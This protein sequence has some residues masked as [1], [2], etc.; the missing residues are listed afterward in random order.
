M[1]FPSQI[2]S[3]T[4][5]IL[6]S[7]KFGPFSKSYKRNYYIIISSPRVITKAIIIK[8]HNQQEC[9][10]KWQE[11]Q[12]WTDDKLATNLTKD[13]QQPLLLLPAKRWLTRCQN[14]KVKG[15]GKR[16]KRE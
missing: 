9:E 11:W 3:K 13:D 16:H 10:N 8:G 15:G 14:L 1:E 7:D 6:F 2:V 5:S 4:C 12:N